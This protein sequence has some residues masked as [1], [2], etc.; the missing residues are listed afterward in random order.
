MKPHQCD[1]PNQES[2]RLRSIRDYPAVIDAKNEP[3]KKADCSC[4]ETRQ[5]N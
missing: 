4:D 2:H 1:P 3:H 5:L